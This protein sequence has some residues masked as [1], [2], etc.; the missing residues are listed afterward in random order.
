VHFHGGGFVAQSS[1][2]HEAY[3]QTWAKEL[4]VCIGL[5]AACCLAVY[6]PETEGL[7]TR[8]ENETMYLDRGQSNIN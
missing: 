4:N 6:G 5:R 1:K 7:G 3:L 8:L 2:S